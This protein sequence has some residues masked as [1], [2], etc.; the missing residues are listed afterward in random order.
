MGGARGFRYRKQKCGVLI[1][2]MTS[3]CHRKNVH[4]VLLCEKVEWGH[5]VAPGAQDR[6]D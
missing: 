3:R 2:K 5:V 6:K 4:R 1:Y